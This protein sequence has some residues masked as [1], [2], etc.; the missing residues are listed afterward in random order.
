MAHSR[1]NTAPLARFSARR[2]LLV[3]VLLLTPT[4]LLVPALLPGR[5][6]LPA[7]LLVQFPPWR[8]QLGELPA[9][10]FDA[11]VWDGIA[12]YYPW[13]HFA[14]ESLRSGHLPLW[15]PYQFCGTPFLANGQ[16][17]VLYPPNLLFWVLPVAVAFAWSAWLH[18]ALTGWFSYLFLRRAV[19]LGRRGADPA[20]AV[21]LLRPLRRA[22]DQQGRVGLA[23]LRR[24]V[25]SLRSG[26]R[27]GLACEGSIV[28]PC[29]CGMCSP[30]DTD[31]LGHFVAISEPCIHVTN[32]CPAV[33]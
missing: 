11:L 9:A 19:G 29:T 10:H 6:L 15:N 12:Q 16:S 18:L 24:G 25:W 27:L 8:A 5:A 1:T 17:A 13:R 20:G 4:L 30:K 3:C 28:I 14:A 23:V 7:D 32:E 31:N 22:A 33:A 21:A 2:F 26:P